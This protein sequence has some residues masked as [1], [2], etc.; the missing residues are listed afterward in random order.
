M[1]IFDRRPGL[2]WAVPA[3]ATAILV[4]AAALSPLAAS[5]DSGLE[6]RTAEEL[7]VALAQPSATAVSGTVVT[8]ADLGL[9]D[10]PMGMTSSTGALAL[11]SGESTLRVWTD[12]PQRQRLAM[13]ERAA[14]TTVVRNGQDV[15]V[16]SSADA[17][18]DRYTLPETEGS[19]PKRLPDGAALPPGVELPS[20]PQ[21][22]AAMALE[23][24]D[25]TTEVTTSGV[26]TVAGRDAYEL[27]LTPRDDATLVAR[28]TLSLDAETNVPLR[29]RVYSTAI[30]DPAFEVGFSAV[31]FAAPD[32]SLFAF[33]PP[34]GATVT[35]H[36]APDTAAM[37]GSGA[38]GAVPAGAEPT[39]VGEGWST[40]VIADLPADGL[41]DLAESGM[42]APSGEGSGAETAGAALALIE[43]LPAES[44]TWGTGRVLRGTLFS[45]ILTDD[46]RVAIG[47]VSPEALG[48]AL[49]AQ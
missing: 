38:M 37:P 11:A 42:R 30:T 31:D 45:V 18:A 29:V 44:G 40:V 32:A 9:P 3:A 36:A 14:E 16:W 48:A 25:P 2:R 4:G 47:A 33:T 41:A 1:S 13:I 7:L 19:I 22:A 28:V 27:V 46:S 35:E 43:A 23:A 10:L 5:A 20:T 21:E 34:P 24:I 8:S 49:A 15:W 12:G 17:T 39:I 26:G 6:P